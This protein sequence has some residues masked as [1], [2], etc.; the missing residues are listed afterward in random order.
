MTDVIGSSTSLSPSYLGTLQ[1]MPAKSARTLSH[2]IHI[3]LRPAAGSVVA[4]LNGSLTIGADC[5]VLLDSSQLANLK[6]D[7]L[8]ELAR[9][10]SVS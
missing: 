1:L 3:I 2:T 8:G 5:S 7:I 4:Q 9:I 10:F 6:Q